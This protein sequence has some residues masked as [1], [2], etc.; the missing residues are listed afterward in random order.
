MNYGYYDSVIFQKTETDY[1]IRVRISMVDSTSATDTTV[2]EKVVPLY[3]LIFVFILAIPFLVLFMTWIM[4]K[5]LLVKKVP[6][7]PTYEEAKKWFEDGNGYFDN[8]SSPEKQ[9]IISKKELPL[10]L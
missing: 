1:R 9:Q 4:L 6:P 5:S 7:Q 2:W 3:F 8:L 10:G